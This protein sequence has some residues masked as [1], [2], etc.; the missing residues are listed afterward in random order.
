LSSSPP[1]GQVRLPALGRLL[2]FAAALGALEGSA[3]QVDLRESL[4]VLSLLA[5]IPANRLAA[6]PWPSF[7]AGDDPANGS[8]RLLSAGHGA[9]SRNPARAKPRINEQ[10]EKG[11][12]M[13]LSRRTLWIGATLA[14]VAAVI[15]VLA[16]FAGGGAGGTGY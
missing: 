1:D 15:V 13:P 5:A 12:V 6:T 16:V 10:Q 9:P 7:S 4:T 8:P 14:I 2:G 3:P 11:G